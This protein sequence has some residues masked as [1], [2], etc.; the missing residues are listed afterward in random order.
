[1][2][3][4]GDVAATNKEGDLELLADGEHVGSPAAWSVRLKTVSRTGL[5]RAHSF[6][7]GAGSVPGSLGKLV[8]ELEA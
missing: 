8:C 5:Q 6:L 7:G 4:T 3:W 2:L 1:M